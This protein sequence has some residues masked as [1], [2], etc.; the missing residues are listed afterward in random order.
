M[1]AGYPPFYDENPFGIYQKILQGKLEFP[2]HFE[3][4]A[5]DLVRKLLTADRA[6]RLGNLRGGGDDVRKHKWFRGLD[7][8]GLF[9]KTLEAP[10]VPETEGEGDTNHFESYPDSDGAD[11]ELLPKE[12]DAELFS[13]F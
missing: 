10:F 6:K 5:R 2:R 13:S 8:V 1:L 7:F 9:Q 4:H 12:T 11:G 3:T